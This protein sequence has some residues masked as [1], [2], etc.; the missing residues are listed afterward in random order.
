MLSSKTSPF[1]QNY[2]QKPSFFVAWVSFYILRCY[3][4]DRNSDSRKIFLF[5]FL[6]FVK[7]I[8]LVRGEILLLLSIRFSSFLWG[9]VYLLLLTLCLC[10]LITFVPDI[11]PCSLHINEFSLFEHFLDNSP[12]MSFHD[13]FCIVFFSVSL[14]SQITLV[15]IYGLCRWLS[16]KE[17]A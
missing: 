8:S 4:L 10:I 16:A 5:F 7:G 17:P 2:F 6:V 14:P 3:D 9:A 1:I 13:L 15:W 12:V 11:I